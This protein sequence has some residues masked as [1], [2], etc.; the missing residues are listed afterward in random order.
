MSLSEFK[1]PSF[2]HQ[3]LRDLFC[4]VA[5][6]LDREHIPYFLEGGA[7]LGVHRA[8]QMIPYD[9][10]IDLGIVGKPFNRVQTLL[11]A[12][13][14]G[15][16]WNIPNRDEKDNL[17]FD[18]TH[19]EKT[20]VVSNDPHLVSIV[21][22]GLHIKHTFPIPTPIIHINQWRNKDGR[23]TLA[24][25]KMRRQYKNHWFKSNELYPLS[26]LMMDNLIFKGPHDGKAY[27]YRAYGQDCL[28]HMK[29]ERSPAHINSQE[30]IINE[31]DT[32]GTALPEPRGEEIIPTDPVPGVRTDVQESPVELLDSRGD[33][34]HG[35][36]E[37]LGDTG[38][39]DQNS[40]QDSSGLFF[41][42]RWNRK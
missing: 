7:L 32:T 13:L 10:N 39:G 11:E 41:W 25:L 17:I 37:Q 16:V 33:Q 38:S 14:S 36:Q 3:V 19:P 42:R 9:V 29:I 30:N 5:D 34:V 8:N 27:L 4:R 1:V 22:P 15:L 23:I 12:G 24:S 20:L 6:I 28:T 26:D 2:H 31:S 35:G 40:D 18:Q 21:V